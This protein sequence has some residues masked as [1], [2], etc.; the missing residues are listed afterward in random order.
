MDDGQGITLCARMDHELTLFC[1]SARSFDSTPVL[2]LFECLFFRG[3][4][5]SDICGGELLHKSCCI[6]GLF[7]I[8]RILAFITSV[9]YFRKSATSQISSQLFLLFSLM[10]KIVFP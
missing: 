6:F 4:S 8:R 1:S 2:D 9:R 5:G 10:F 3:L 7:G